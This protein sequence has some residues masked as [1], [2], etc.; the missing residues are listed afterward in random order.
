MIKASE[1]IH[2]QKTNKKDFEDCLN[3]LPHNHFLDLKELLEKALKICKVNEEIKE[4]MKE[5]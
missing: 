1:I 5:Y 3:V 2:N 4:M